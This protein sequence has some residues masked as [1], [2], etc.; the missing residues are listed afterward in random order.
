M[1]RS[2]HN[3]TAKYNAFFLA[4]EKMKEAEK[5]LFLSRKDDYNKILDVIPPNDSNQLSKVKTV[6]EDCIKKCG[7]VINFHPY[8]KWVGASYELVGRSRFY[9][10]DY[11]NAITTFKYVNTKGLEESAVHR[12]LINLM[13]TFLA[14]NQMGDAKTVMN[15]LKGENLNKVNLAEFNLTRA[16]YFRMLNNYK[17][18]AKYL[19]RAVPLMH[20][21]ER[22]G[23]IYFILG[24]IFH[25]FNRPNEALGYYKKVLVN[26]PTY[27]MI[28]YSK[29]SMA[30]VF[31]IET[32]KDEKKIQKYFKTL[33]A[34]SKNKDFEDKIYYE[35]GIFELRRQDF[36][37]AVLHLQKSASVSANPSQKAYSYLKLAEIHYDN[38]QRYEKAKQYYDSAITNLP[39]DAENYDRIVR[40]YKVLDKFVSNLNTV[41]LQDS[42]LRYARLDSNALQARLSYE[43]QIEERQRQDQIER[44]EAEA[45]KQAAKRKTSGSSLASSQ[46]VA[47]PWYFYNTT[48]VALGKREFQKQWGNRQLADNWRRSL[49]EE[50]VEVDSLVKTKEVVVDREQLIKDRVEQRKTALLK[51]IPFSPEAQTTS[52]KKVEEAPLNL[53]K[54]YKYDLAEPRNA[55]TSF[56]RLLK[57]FPESKYAPEVLYSLYLLHT[58]LK[59]NLAAEKFKT[60]LLSTFPQSVYAKL[61]ENPNYLVEAEKSQ[62]SVNFAYRQ[63][64]ELYQNGQFA[65]AEQLIGQTLATFKE[66]V[67]AD[68]FEYLQVLI[69]LR[70]KDRLM[71]IAN[72]E[73][74]IQ[75]FPESLLIEKARSLLGRAKQMEE[76]K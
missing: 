57:D 27:E 64:Y 46:N 40:R 69:D 45:A 1:G 19:E 17:A 21:G 25:E 75:K 20:R 51:I 62:S 63:A 43:L 54:I 18:V 15:F 73:A 7:M 10:Q 33:L 2:Y 53:G 5:E 71:A 60:E 24:Q 22:K 65:Q 30:Q 9:M 72:L 68:K 39:K 56:E 52:L 48:A 14:L 67:I 66:M 6:M 37:K 76:G 23:R 13:R 32:A 3:I 74:F 41:R 26:N 59:N 58:D 4:R 34:D 55:I 35:M 50:E 47:G 49:R 28:F 61:I 12:S 42:L 29:L 8:S 16:Q 31:P 70:I 36:A 38:L 44:L 11:E